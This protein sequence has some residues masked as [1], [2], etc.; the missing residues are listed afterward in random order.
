MPVQSVPENNLNN[1]Y[2]HVYNHGIE[3]NIIFNDE[4]DYKVFLNYLKEYLS[5][6]NDPESSKKA[7]SIRGQAFR[8]TPHQPKNYYEK[9]EL[10]AYGF[11]PNHFHLLLILK[12]KKFLQGFIRSLCTRYSIYF[13][14]KHHR[15]GSLFNG[16]YKSILIKDEISVLH[17]TRYLHTHKTSSYPEYIGEKITPWIKPY[18]NNFSK[19]MVDYKYT[20]LLEKIILENTTQNIKVAPIIKNSPRIPEFIVLNTL[21]FFLLTMGVGNILAPSTAQYNLFTFPLTKKY[22]AKIAPS[23]TSNVLG[24]ETKVITATKDIK[25]KEYISIDINDDQE[26]VEIYKEENINSEKIGWAKNGEV[27]ELVSKNTEWMEIKLTNGSTGFVL[28][29]YIKTK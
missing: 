29:K 13:N 25:P 10:V 14:K 18:K 24:T 23:T 19:E 22:I 12:H 11:S 9:I 16:P 15:K 3:N 26:S 2:C 4:S 21:F 28:S 20:E 6:P 17:L 8:G 5:P 27:F 7:F 1:L